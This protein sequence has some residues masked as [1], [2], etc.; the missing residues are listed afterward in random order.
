MR[1]QI[2]RVEIDGRPAAAEDLRFLALNNYGHFTAM[3]VRDRGVRGLAV[4]LT[5]LANANREMFDID[6]DGDL[7][8]A[9][10]RH[11]LG[12]ITDASVRTMIMASGDD[13]PFV[14]V[15]VRPPA[16]TTA[17]PHSMRSVPYQ[18]PLPHLKQVGGGFGQDYYQRIAHRAGFAEAL[19]TGPDGLIAEGAISNI[20]FF[21]GSTIV[22]PNAPVLA[23]ITMQLVRAHADLTSRESTVRLSDLDDYPAIFVT[24]ARGI[25]PVGRIDDQLTST[26]E[27]F[28]KILDQTYE[29]V[30]WDRI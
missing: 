29:S 12:D 10:I 26:D 25:R 1:D 8:R 11:A 18:R 4:H 17:G 23:G 6:L 7:V 3:Q 20:G 28:M 16:K 30:P 5:R 9:H 24:N 21:D 14:V 22:W 19:L 27:D 2:L 13:T 15:T